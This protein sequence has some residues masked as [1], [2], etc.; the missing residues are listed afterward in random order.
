MTGNRKLRLLFTFYQNFSIPALLIS[1]LCAFAFYKLGIPF[2]TSLIWFKLITL[3]LFLYFVNNYK[4]KEY[5]YYQ[6]LGISKN[7]LIGWTVT[8]HLFIFIIMLIFSDKFSWFI[9]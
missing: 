8:A 4:R 5:Y 1:V 6:N 2:L 9:D 7:A 3:S